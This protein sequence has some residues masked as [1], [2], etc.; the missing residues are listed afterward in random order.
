MDELYTTLPDGL[1]GNEDCG[2]MS[3]WSVLSS[4]GFYPVTPGQDIYAIGTPIFP[5]ATINLEN[6]NQFVIKANNVSEKNIYIQSAKLNG[7]NYTK[8][9]I[10]H[11][12]IMNG[13]ELVFEMGETPNKDWGSSDNDIPVSE[14][15]DNVI[16]PVPYVETGSRTFIGS[17]EVTLATV[18]EGAQIYYTLDGTEPTMNSKV[19]IEPLKLIETTTIKAFSFVDGMPISN[20]ITA[21]FN[22][23]KEGRTIEIIS[24]YENQFSAG[25]D[26]ALI[27][28]IR[29]P[30]NF[31]TGAWQGF[32]GKDLEVIVNLG[33]VQKV[34]M[35]SASFIQDIG[36]WIFMPMQVEYY[37]SNDGKNF[38]ELK[39][40]EN[41]LS[42]RH[43]GTNIKSFTAEELN[44]STQYVKVIGRSIIDCPDWHKGYGGKAWLFSDE[45]IIE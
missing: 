5:K 28:H 6:E 22:K 31:R 3:S 44:I 45:I 17:T 8:S 25:G 4:L 27:D 10:A 41:D 29:G 11:S 15:T 32:Q 35:L 18:T 40:V 43:M 37:I 26:M 19:F 20:V 39:V 23:I 42:V 30:G 21:E 7:Q 24:E 13:G 2:Q 36:A 16:I 12:D 14:I 34:N 9:F 33:S 1:S 38:K